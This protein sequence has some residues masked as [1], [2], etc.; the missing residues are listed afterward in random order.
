MRKIKEDT[1][2]SEPSLLNKRLFKVT[3]ID[4]FDIVP[5]LSRKL[6]CS[7]ATMYRT[8]QRAKIPIY[9]VPNRS[10]TVLLHSASL[11]Q[12]ATTP[13][14]KKYVKSIGLSSKTLRL[15]SNASTERYDVTLAQALESGLLPL[16][17][18]QALL[19]AE[20]GLIPHKNKVLEPWF[21]MY[22]EGSLKCLLP[23]KA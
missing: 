11:W 3:S 6:G 7:Q 15:E 2:G 19:A 10:G 12:L 22:L 23:R 18:K 16:T 8:L 21:V 1:S 4:D 17:P 20:C 14:F 5:S 13:V 9:H